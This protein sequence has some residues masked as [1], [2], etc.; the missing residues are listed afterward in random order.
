MENP[1]MR[2]QDLTRRTGPCKADFEGMRHQ[3][4]FEAPKIFLELNEIRMNMK[5]NLQAR[6]NN[7][8]DF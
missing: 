6:K 1:N 8:L 3:F 4:H 2:W 5:F 7:P